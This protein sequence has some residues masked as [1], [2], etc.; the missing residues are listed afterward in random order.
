MSKKWHESPIR[1]GVYDFLKKEGT[2]E[3]LE[4]SNCFVGSW[5]FHQGQSLMIR[6]SDQGDQVAYLLRWTEDLPANILIPLIR[7]VMLSIIANAI[8]G[9]SPMTGPSGQI[10]S[11]RARYANATDDQD[12]QP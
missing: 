9:V 12:A 11:M 10:F 5:E 6:F 2:E 4:W 3:F 7:K 8:I 1:D